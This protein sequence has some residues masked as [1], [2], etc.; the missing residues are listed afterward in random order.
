MPK[1]LQPMDED[2]HGR[3][4]WGRRHAQSASPALNSRPAPA[5]AAMEAEA[6]PLLRCGGSTSTDH[7]VGLGS[8]AG[9]GVGVSAGGRAAAGA[10][11][12]GGAGV[13]T[14][15]GA[16]DGPGAPAPPLVVELV[17]SRPSDPLLSSPS[18]AADTPTHM[19]ANDRPSVATANTMRRCVV[20]TPSSSVARGGPSALPCVRASRGCVRWSASSS[21]A[22]SRT[23]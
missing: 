1:S 13:I 2:D 11:V 21:S 20:K 19:S 5:S 9:E 22:S 16:P 7:C 14:C 15:P 8:A 6:L 3:D 18:C 4:P 10:S 12:G 17:P 23:A